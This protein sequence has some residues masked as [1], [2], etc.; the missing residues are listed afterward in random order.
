VAS[1]I[2]VPEAL[3]DAP[4]VKRSWRV[5]GRRVLAPTPPVAMRRCA[6]IR[7]SAVPR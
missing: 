2:L 3:G 4:F 1:K 6:L 5:P 7:A